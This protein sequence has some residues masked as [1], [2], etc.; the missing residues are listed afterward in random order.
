MRGSIQAQIEYSK[1]SKLKNKQW[2]A[3]STY[4]FKDFTLPYS[5]KQFRVLF[6]DTNNLMCNHDQHDGFIQ[7][8]R[9]DCDEMF[10][11]NPKNLTKAHGVSM[12]VAESI[13]EYNFKSTRA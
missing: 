8:E 6:L 11:K 10:Y 1:V 13:I 9:W 3:P 2:I 12:Q 4:Y 5:K 7:V